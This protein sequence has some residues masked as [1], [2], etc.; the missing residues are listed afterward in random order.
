MGRCFSE[1]NHYSIVGFCNEFQEH[2]RIVRYLP[3]NRLVC[4][5][6]R[7]GGGF[8]NHPDDIPEKSKYVPVPRER[9][10]QSKINRADSYPSALWRCITFTGNLSPFF[11]SLI[12]QSSPQVLF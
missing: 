8:W 1:S 9:E 12:L 10:D 2:V 4:I 5:I 6:C 11:Q 7:I 3:E